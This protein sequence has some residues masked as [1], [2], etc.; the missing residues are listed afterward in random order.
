[1]WNF[2]TIPRLF[3]FLLYGSLWNTSLNVHIQ[4]PSAGCEHELQAEAHI[5]DIKPYSSPC[6]LETH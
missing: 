1:M 5:N 6:L 3:L 2:L 4:Q